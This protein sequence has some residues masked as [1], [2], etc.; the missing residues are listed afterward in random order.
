MIKELIGYKKIKGAHTTSTAPNS[1]KAQS[2]VGFCATYDID[3]TQCH[4][5]SSRQRKDQKYVT[6]SCY[7]IMKALESFKAQRGVYPDNVP[8][9][10]LSRQGKDQEYVTQS[11]DLMVKA[12]ESFKAKRG[13]YPEDVIVYRDGQDKD[14]EQKS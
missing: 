10:A 14:Q 1:D 5:Q 8:R 6:Q 11:C 4:S 2:V 9:W 7:L 13:V 12:S 3:H